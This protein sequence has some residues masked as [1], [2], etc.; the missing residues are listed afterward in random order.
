MTVIEYELKEIIKPVL[1]DTT[2]KQIEEPLK[3]I[4]NQFNEK[5]RWYNK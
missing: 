1:F 5:V 3:H 2:P 4:R